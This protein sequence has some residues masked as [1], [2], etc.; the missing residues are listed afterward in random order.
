M[1]I[2]STLQT[3]AGGHENQDRASAFVFGSR[4]FLVVADGAGGIT[5]GAIAAD[6]AIKFVHSQADQM[7]DSTFCASVLQDMDQ[8]ICKNPSAGE[9]TCAVAVIS[10]DQIY[11]AS[12]GDSG[13]WIIDEVGV[14]DLTRYQSRKPFVGS[15]N[16][17]AIPF[18]NNKSFGAYL[19]LAT[20]GLLKYASREQIVTVC[21]ESTAEL[22]AKRLIELVRYPSGALP[23]DVTVILTKM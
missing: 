1:N 6:L 20:D 19:L 8:S 9:T 16:A 17:R 11:G 13:V 14:I 18:K 12:V 15:G 7:S 5:G 4:R 2:S 3:E 22:A 21:R 23:D 10:E